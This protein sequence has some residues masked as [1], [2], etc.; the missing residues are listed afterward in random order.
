[1]AAT[2]QTLSQGAFSAAKDLFAHPFAT[3]PGVEGRLAAEGEL[4][5]ALPQQLQAVR[6]LAAANDLATSAVAPAARISFSRID[7]SS[8]MENFMLYEDRP[9]FGNSALSGV[10]LVEGTRTPGAG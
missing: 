9:D 3:R 10:I 2:G 6:A 8:P 7:L 4:D 5:D 1:M